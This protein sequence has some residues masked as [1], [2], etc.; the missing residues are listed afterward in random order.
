M[1]GCDGV[2]ECLVKEKDGRICAEV[3]CPEDA[4]A[5]VRAFITEANRTLP[6]YKRMTA[7]E[8]RSEPF[9]KNATGKIVQ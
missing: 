9:P 8:F 1:A 7:V 2:Q 5:A 6:L 3:Y 4:Q